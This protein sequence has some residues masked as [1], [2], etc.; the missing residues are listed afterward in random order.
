MQE[1]YTLLQ[2][3]NYAKICVKVTYVN[4][5]Y[6]LL[7][8]VLSLYARSSPIID[9]DDEDDEN[10]GEEWVFPVPDKKSKYLG[11]YICIFYNACCYKR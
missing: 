7:S 11:T 8:P 5:V 1:S 6:Y 4:M 10:E 2:Y 9:S 3:K